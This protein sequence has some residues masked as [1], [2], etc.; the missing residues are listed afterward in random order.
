MLGQQVFW[1]PRVFGKL[2]TDVVRPELLKNFNAR[3]SK[4]GGVEAGNEAITLAHTASK[5]HFRAEEER[6]DLPFVPRT[7]SS[8]PPLAS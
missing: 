4:E 3:G 2:G 1:R 6:R 5:P 8:S 7:C